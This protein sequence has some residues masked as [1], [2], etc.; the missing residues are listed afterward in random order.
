MALALAIRKKSRIDR[1][2]VL[3]RPGGSNTFSLGF[4]V[5]FCRTGG[6]LPFGRSIT[7]S[8]SVTFYFLHQHHRLNGITP[9]PQKFP[10]R[11]SFPSVYKRTVIF[12]GRVRTDHCCA[13][14]P[15]GPLRRSGRASFLARGSLKTLRPEAAIFKAGSR[16]KSRTGSANNAEIGQIWPYV[17][18]F[19]LQS[20]V[21]NAYY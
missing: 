3:K 4:T 17:R 1:R 9:A 6:S 8:A 14:L 12:T 20:L 19:F 10:F 11:A 18:L 2:P 21:G 5:P 7:T 16:R 15:Q 13:C